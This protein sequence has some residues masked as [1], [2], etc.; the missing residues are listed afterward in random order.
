MTLH[1][2]NEDF[3]AAIEATAQHLNI[4]PVFIEKDYW[5]TYVLRNLSQ[6]KYKAELY[7]KEVLLFPKRMDVSS[8]FQKIL[9]LLLFLRIIIPVTS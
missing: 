2:S 9:T 7:L 8:G 5:V 1:Q 6:S 4:R 3:K